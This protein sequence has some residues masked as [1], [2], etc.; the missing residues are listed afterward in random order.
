MVGKVKSMC[1]STQKAVAVI[2]GKTF[3]FTAPETQEITKETLIEICEELSHRHFF[4][5]LKS[6]VLKEGQYKTSSW[7]SEYPS[8]E[9]ILTCLVDTFDSSVKELQNIDPILKDAY[10]TFSIS[11]SENICDYATGIEEIVKSVVYFARIRN[12]RVKYEKEIGRYFYKSIS[13]SISIRGIQDV[14]AVKTYAYRNLLVS[15]FNLY[16]DQE[17]SKIE[18]RMLNDELYQNTTEKHVVSKPVTNVFNKVNVNDNVNKFISDP[19]NIEEIKNYNDTLTG[20]FESYNSNPKDFWLDKL[21]PNMREWFTTKSKSYTSIDVD[22][23]CPCVLF[24]YARIQSE[25]SNISISDSFNAL[26]KVID[27]IKNT[28]LVSVPVVA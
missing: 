1:T 2:D 13:S 8:F 11:T 26:K 22:D 9:N 24:E 6:K 7:T 16:N 25:K 14:Q 12:I 3:E 10:F 18:G 28:K 27:L 5:V 23:R 21:T 19:K 20:L 17:I 15:G 4:K